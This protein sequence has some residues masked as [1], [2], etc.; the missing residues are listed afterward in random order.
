MALEPWAC[1]LDCV[2]VIVTIHCG[3]TMPIKAYTAP[4]H[5]CAL[6]TGTA[7]GG[8]GTKDA[9][10]YSVQ[11]AWGRP[12]CANS[13][14]GLL[15]A[16]K[17]LLHPGHL[18]VHCNACKLCLLHRYNDTAEGE[19]WRSALRPKELLYTKLMTVTAS[20]SMS[21]SSSSCVAAALT[22]ELAPQPANLQ[23]A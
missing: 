4:L 16:F 6:C 23:Q 12:A 9:H 15:C 8:A 1:H 20:S 11:H 13:R 14:K 7:Q 21:A 22:T 2:W 10:L 3:V 19:H 5:Y 18:H 17:A